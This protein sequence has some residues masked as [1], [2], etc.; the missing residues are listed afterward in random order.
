MCEL[1]RT[2]RLYFVFQNDFL[3]SWLCV[4]R[5]WPKWNV[6]KTI[7]GLPGK[8]KPRSSGSSRQPTIRPRPDDDLESV[9]EKVDPKLAQKLRAKLDEEYCTSKAEFVADIASLQS[10]QRIM[11]KY[12]CENW[13]NMTEENWWKIIKKEVK[14]FL[15]DGYDI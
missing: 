14:Q 3:K 5:N 15:K 11:V 6:V 10:D 1:A 12:V 13:D 4:K 8:K 7:Q 2:N 9:Y